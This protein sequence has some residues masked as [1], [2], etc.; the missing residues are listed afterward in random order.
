MVTRFAEMWLVQG[1]FDTDF[2]EG[3]EQL[4][5]L[6]LNVLGM[7]GKPAEPA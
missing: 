1:L 2:D 7:R 4:T 5:R 6:F 3:V